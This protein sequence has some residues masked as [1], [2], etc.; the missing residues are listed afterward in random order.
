MTD[1]GGDPMTIDTTTP[2]AAPTITHASAFDWAA[3]INRLYASPEA[4][5]RLSADY[6]TGTVAGVDLCRE[7]V[8]STE[9][10]HSVMISAD[11]AWTVLYDAAQGSWRAL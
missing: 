11:F 7:G 3:A 6:A 2:A 1:P 8:R 5:K 9:D 4:Q 10:D